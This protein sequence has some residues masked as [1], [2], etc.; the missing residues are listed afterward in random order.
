MANFYVELARKIL[1]LSQHPM[2]PREILDAA[3]KTGLIP[4]KYS[5]AKTPHKTIHARL[6][7]SIR[8]QGPKSPFYRFARGKFGL[9][10]NLLN[11]GYQQQFAKEYK[12]TIRRKEIS[13][14]DV[15]CVRRENLTIDDT[16]G[17]FSISS[18]R[19][20]VAENSRLVYVA[21]KDA[22]KDF[23]LKQIVTYVA[24]LRG[25][26]V[27]CYERGTYSATGQE[28][29]G[30]KSI[31]FGGHIDAEDVNLFSRDEYGIVS[32]AW[33]EL[34]E[35]LNLIENSVLGQGPQVV[36]LIND[37]TTKE[38][39]KH[40][41]VA[42]IVQ[43]SPSEDLTKGELEIRNLHWKSLNALPN[44]IVQFE[45]W[46]RIFFEYIV[47]HFDRLVNANR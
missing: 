39:Q 40:L 19:D 27:L 15:L 46:S 13:N 6:A 45:V 21:R 20:L 22:E 7:E 2:S 5:R 28:L 4:E 8:R 10:S 47:K 30:S 31:G 26:H 24:V 37:N 11:L 3:K 41:A 18:Y 32:N 33:R 16:N 44:D 35:E 25:R 29:I 1:E 42:M 43:C 36:G 34:S 12:A 9:R 38:G 14:E 23:S 17:F